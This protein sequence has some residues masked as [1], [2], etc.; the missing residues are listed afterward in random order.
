MVVGGAQ[1]GSFGMPKAHP[2]LVKRGAGGRHSLLTR[3]LLACIWLGCA[4]ASG[5]ASCENPPLSRA[6]SRTSGP[7][8]GPVVVPGEEGEGRVYEEILSVVDAAPDASG[9]LLLDG[10][11][12]R[13]HILSSSGDLIRS[14]G[15]PGQGPGE[16]SLPAA[17][18]ALE[19]GFAVADVT[20]R[21]VEIFSSDGTFLRKS[22]LPPPRCGSGVIQ[23]LASDDGVSLLVLRRCVSPY[24]GGWLAELQRVGPDGATTE[25]HSIALSDPDRGT[26]NP[27]AIPVL[28]TQGR[29]IYLGV[30]TD[31]CLRHIKD[32]EEA[33]TPL[34]SILE[35]T[36]PIPPELRSALE[37]LKERNARVSPVRLEIPD[38]LPHFDQIF[39]T[40]R[41]LVLRLV[42]GRESRT[43]CLLDQRDGSCSWS[44]HGDE[45]SYVGDST[46]LQVVE[47]AAGTRIVLTPFPP[48]SAR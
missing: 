18:T 48:D 35:S 30:T 13:V 44:A 38:E 29:D 17:I 6:S 3:M 42:S 8:E 21:R 45:G 22:V 32:G 11:A 40:Q 47:E 16:L 19:D 28:A 34:C 37:D 24:Q 31:P 2:Y 33:P 4:A 27:L 26:L 36:I 9:W 12:A 14:V 15:G 25:L 43:L 10:R 23:D 39:A 5:L 46:I 41:G 7:P 20:G 1:S